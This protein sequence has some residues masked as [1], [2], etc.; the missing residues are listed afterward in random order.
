MTYKKPFMQEDLR[1]NRLVA[2]LDVLME[3]D[4]PLTVG[5]VQYRLGR[6]RN[7]S[8]P[9]EEI[10]AHLDWGLLQPGAT[11]APV[12]PHRIYHTD[13]WTITAKVPLTSE[14][15]KAA[16][17]PPFEQSKHVHKFV[18][19]HTSGNPYEGGIIYRKCNCDIIQTAS[20]DGT[21]TL[22]KYDSKAVLE[23]LSEPRMTDEEVRELYR[24]AYS[25]D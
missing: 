9:R 17:P 1:S 16:G 20:E 3:A 10:K 8:L 24:Q 15:V 21:F 4:E 6:D 5:Q 18:R 7:L 22:N 23:R 13:R 14:Q 25:E 2:I 11:N 19:F 12:R